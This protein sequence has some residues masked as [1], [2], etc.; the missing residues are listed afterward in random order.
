MNV[1]FRGH[2]PSLH[3]AGYGIYTEGER[4]QLLRNV[5]AKEIT[6]AEA[7][8]AKNGIPK[9]TVRNDLNHLTAALGFSSVKELQQAF[10]DEAAADRKRILQ[11]IDAYK[12][13]KSGPS[14]FVSESEACI[15]ANVH[16]LDR[17]AGRGVGRKDQ[18]DVLRELTHM[19]G[20]AMMDMAVKD[21]EK[22]QAR[23]FLDAKCGSSFVRNFATQQVAPVAEHGRL[24]SHVKASPPTPTPL[25][26]SQQ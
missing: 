22:I 12:F 9:Q 2:A 23:R 10:A 18:G 11:A 19:K 25:Q 26:A 1:A 8:S 15:L 24:K 7:S 14:P 5:V 20:G 3:G 21:K 4:R 17:L 13:L 6:I 16:D